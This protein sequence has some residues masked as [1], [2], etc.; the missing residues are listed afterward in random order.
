VEALRAA[1]W[2]GVLD[3]AGLVEAA[4][5][6]VRSRADRYATVLH[7]GA[8]ELTGVYLDLLRALDGPGRVTFFAPFRPGARA[9]TYAERFARRHLLGQG[10][11]PRMLPDGAGAVLGPGLD[12]LWVEE[13]PAFRAP[14]GALVLADVQGPEAELTYGLRR[15]L[16]AVAPE[17]GV[18][19]AEVAVLARSLAPYRTVLEADEAP[20]PLT[21]SI[22][23]PLRRD[24]YV[25]DLL[26]LL[27]ILRTDFPRGRTAE[28]LRSPRV[29][30]GCR[31][32]SADGWSRQAAVLGGLDAWVEDLPLW[33]GSP[34]SPRTP[35]WRSVRRRRRAHGTAAS[36]RRRSPPP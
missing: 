12:H 2:R 35:A 26:L 6:H 16:G 13:G 36:A 11:E 27:E 7:H 33:A 32:E 1:A 20:L 29:R 22:A 19:P 9:T 18:P 10:A 3:D 31:G 24:P 14:E 8:Y 25:H 21:S 28:A 5:P 30:W 23:L 15:A 34:A 17:D 4:L